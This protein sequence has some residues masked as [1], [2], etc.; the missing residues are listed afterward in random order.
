MVGVLVVMVVVVVVV[1]EVEVVV[2][3]TVIGTLPTFLLP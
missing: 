2:G 1:V 3:F